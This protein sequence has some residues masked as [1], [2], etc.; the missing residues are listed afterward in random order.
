MAENGRRGERLGVRGGG[1]CVE[2]L[3]NTLTYTGWFFWEERASKHILIDAL[4]FLESQRSAVPGKAEEG[5]KK[6]SEIIS[7]ELG[8]LKVS[9]E[10]ALLAKNRKDQQ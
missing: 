9:N 7:T 1:C 5:Y 3:Y 2:R 4:Q 10:D 6:K 8:N